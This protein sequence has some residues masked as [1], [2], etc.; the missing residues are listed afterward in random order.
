MDPEDGA[1]VIIM[2]HTHTETTEAFMKTTT[3]MA[4]IRPT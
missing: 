4:P 1:H 3:G 2:V